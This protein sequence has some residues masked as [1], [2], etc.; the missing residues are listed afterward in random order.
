MKLYMQCKIRRDDMTKECTVRHSNLSQI[1]LKIRK[2][3][4]CSRRLNTQSR[5]SLVPCIETILFPQY[6]HSDYLWRNRWSFILRDRIKFEYL[7]IKAIYF[8][9]FFFPRQGFSV[10]P[11]LSWNS[12]CRPGWPQ[13]QK[14]A[15]LCL[16]SAGIKGV[17]HY[18]P[19]NKS[20]LKE[21]KLPK[22][23]WF[24]LWISRAVFWSWF[25][26]FCLVNSFLVEIM[27]SCQG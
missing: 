11:W 17:C 8:F 14:S 21:L 18:G 6:A 2:C 13:T 1:E 20:N 23:K 3:L 16:T 7:E 15:C 19:A 22:E 25:W 5:D 12:L 4:C 24:I 27:A 26:T 9:S 10:K